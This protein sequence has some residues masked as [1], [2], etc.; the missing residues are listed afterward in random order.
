[1]IAARVAAMAALLASAPASAFHPLITD[2]AGT[3]G[4]GNVEI[5]LAVQHEHDT[6]R[7][8]DRTVESI[9]EGTW[10]RVSYRDDINQAGICVCYG[11]IDSLDVAVGIPYLH[12]RTKERRSVYAPGPLQ[13]LAYRSTSTAT[14]A[15]DLVIAFKWMFFEVNGLSLA[16]KPGSTFPIGNED[17]GFGSGRISPYL[18]FILSHETE[19]VLT[20][21]NIGYIRNE[22]NQDRHEDLWHASLAFEFRAV[23]EYLRFVVNGGLERCPNKCSRVQNAFVLGGVVVSPTRDFDIDLGFKY[24]IALPG[25]ESPG[26]DLTA[27][28]GLTFRFSTGAPAAPPMAERKQG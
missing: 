14:G 16:L 7:S 28:G 1:M 22:N 18:Y 9:I 12:V 21:L 26:P 2:D 8:F 17:Q 11:I 15:G 27:M 13:G 5:E 3:R 6:Y 23:K 20:H 25:V 24:S 19:Y 10:G 4:R